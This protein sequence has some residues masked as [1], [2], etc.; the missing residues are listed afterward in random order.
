MIRA[1][2]I[3]TFFLLMVSCG[4][5]SKSTLPFSDIIP[6][7]SLQHISADR[8]FITGTRKD[9]D[10]E[11]IWVYRFNGEK[12]GS[13]EYFN[14]WQYNGDYYLGVNY[15]RRFYFFPKTNTTIHTSEVYEDAIGS[16]IL[17]DSNNWKVFT[18]DGE[19]LLSLPQDARVVHEQSTGQLYWLK[20]E[21]GRVSVYDIK[22]RQTVK[23][24][25]KETLWEPQGAEVRTLS[26][27]TVLA[28]P[29]FLLE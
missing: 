15:T 13:F 5:N 24:G 4:N 10:V 8:C 28:V 2:Y 20:E 18:C 12:V 16:I 27:L 9:G 25:S 3:M 17:Q 29:K 6:A 26:S 21:K 14:H 19:L 22:N 7:D 1:F 11:K 23:E